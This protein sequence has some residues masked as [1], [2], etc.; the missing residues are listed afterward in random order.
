MI[1]GLV[2]NVDFGWIR[3]CIEKTQKKNNNSLDFD[4]QYLGIRINQV[5]NNILRN[6]NQ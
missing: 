3:Y 4:A 1:L 5:L 2:L 6:M